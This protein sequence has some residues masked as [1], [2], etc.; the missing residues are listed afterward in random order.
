MRRRQKRN[1]IDKLRALLRGEVLCFIS[2]F[3]VKIYSKPSE[4]GIGQRPVFVLYYSIVI[5]W[6]KEAIR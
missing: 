3:I 6:I 1:F 2:F 5:I 4:T